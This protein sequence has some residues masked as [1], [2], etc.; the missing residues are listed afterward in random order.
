MKD[1][2][3]EMSCKVFKQTD[4]DYISAKCHE[5]FSQWKLLLNRAEQASVMLWTGDGSELLDYDGNLDTNF[6]WCYWV[7]DAPRRKSDGE[8]TKGHIYMK[9]PPKMTYAILK[10][11]VS[12]IKKAGKDI[13][14]DNIK[15]RVGTTFDPG[16]EFAKSSFKYE[17]HNELCSGYASSGSV[18]ICAYEK[19]KGDSFHYAAY[20]NGV[21]DGLPFGTFF[22]KQAH[23]FM[24]DMGFD[25][26]WLSNGFGFGKDTWSPTGA[27]F[28]GEQFYPNSLE[29]TKEKVA[30]FWKLFTNELG[31]FAIENR[32]TNLSMGIDLS[33]DGVPLKQIY[34]GD[35]DL[36]PPPN[37]PWAAL[38][39]DYGLE[40]MGYMSRISKLPAD[41]YLFRYYIHD[42][43]FLNSPWYDRYNS[44]PHDIYLPLSVARIDRDGSVMPPTNMHL[45][46]V[47]NSLGNL[48]EACCVE[49]LPHLLKAIK[50]FPDAPA[51][52]VWVYPFDEYSE[53]IDGQD[54][55][56]MYS[57]DWFIRNAI[58][59]GLPLSMVTST[60]DFLIHDKII[61]AGSVL[62][63]PVPKNGSTFEKAILAYI[64][65]GGKVIFY[66][67]TIKAGSAFKELFGLTYGDPI[68]GEL[69]IIVDNRPV[70]KVCHTPV[71]SGG[72]FFEQGTTAEAFAT[73]ENRPVAVRKD[74]CVWI[75]GTVSCKYVSRNA[76]LQMYK[77]N[78]Y[79]LAEK[80]IV[81]A[82]AFFGYELNFEKYAYERSPVIMLHRN[83]NAFIISVF[84]DSTTVK[85]SL[86]FPLGAPILDAYETV[87]ENGRAIYHFP[88]SERREIRAF[89]E[90]ESGIV[91]CREYPP[92]SHD[93]RCRRRIEISGLENA[94]VRFLGE[95]YCAENLEVQLDP[96]GAY[97]S[98]TSKTIQWSY[99]TIEGTKICQIE[100][101]T[102]SLIFNMPF[103]DGT[104]KPISAE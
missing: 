10:T 18:M 20:P 8:Y 41:R 21:P 104:Q 30:G 62:I 42:P 89:V 16:P 71:I 91:K 98:R 48:P 90:Q 86:R 58:N 93:W 1:I 29:N 63:T 64:D 46:S 36:L 83:N 11:I 85:T 76:L 99:L 35:Y 5:V 47:D 68:S 25:F 56:Q 34:D 32:G 50:Q 27:I 69:D 101:V 103:P 102:G 94:T 55:K 49:P 67:N 38:N 2:T 6:E 100:N 39:G 82:L 9:N 60:T 13:L 73:I 72:D 24:N 40:I 54:M 78:E 88:K 61:Y 31:N 84:Q 53:C 79:Y 87:L 81:R 43:W 4:R 96:I 65:N 95:T 75:R 74:N 19:M 45:F 51:P 23:I 33:R 37:S 17:R 28:D 14:G 80:L 26:I 12:E 44:Q 70:G 66:G 92:T 15:I 57:E 77:E 22:G 59:L 52:F 7:S 97:Q 3:L